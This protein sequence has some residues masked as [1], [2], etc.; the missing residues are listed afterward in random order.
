M[1]SIGDLHI[2]VHDFNL[3]LRFYTE[4]LGLTVAEKEISSASAFAL[5]EFPAAG[6]AVR[7]FGGAEPWA[8]GTRPVVGSRP[9]VHFDV[10]ASDF[11]TTLVRLVEN[12]GRQ[13]G[14]IETYGN[15]RVVTIADPDGNTFELLEVPEDPKE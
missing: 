13:I 12:G 3:A 5:L 10:I 14:E 15:S 11:D 2:F 1:L 8:E 6:P 7:L 9:T 4:G